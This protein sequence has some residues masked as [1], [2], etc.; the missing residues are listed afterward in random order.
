[1]DCEELLRSGHNESGVYTIWPRSRIMDDKSLDVFCDMDTDGGGWTLLNCGA[2]A[3]FVHRV[4]ISFRF[5]VRFRINLIYFD[6]EKKG[7]GSGVATGVAT[8]EKRLIHPITSI[9]MYDL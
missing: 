9:Y 4:T 8:K 6:A 5:I 7:S 1:M 2:Q 3:W